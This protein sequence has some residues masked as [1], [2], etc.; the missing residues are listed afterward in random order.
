MPPEFYRKLPKVTGTALVAY[1]RVFALARAITSEA[2]HAVNHHDIQ[3]FLQEY[4][5]QQPLAMGELWALPTMLRIVN[6]ENLTWA[7]CEIAEAPL[8]EVDYELPVAP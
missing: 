4:Q 2:V 6:L 5:T 3:V 1:P 8:P 7:V